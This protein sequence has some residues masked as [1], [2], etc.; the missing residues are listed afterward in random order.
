MPVVDVVQFAAKRANGKERAW[1]GVKLMKLSRE[2]LEVYSLWESDP[3]TE[4]PDQSE[5]TESR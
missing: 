2:F 3:E 4:I 5:K 1:L